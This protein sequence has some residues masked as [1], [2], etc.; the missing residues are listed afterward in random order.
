MDYSNTSNPV[1]KDNIFSIQDAS[2]ESMTIE[3]VLR[4]SL[5]AFCLL[6]GGAVFAWTRSYA[7]IGDISGK[8]ALFSIGAI[9]LHFITIFNANIAK[10]TVPLYAFLEGLILGSVSWMAQRY[11]PGI[12]IQAVT[13]TLGVFMA[14]L[15]V[16]RMGIIRPNEKFTMVL[17]VAT[18]GIGFIYLANWLLSLLGFSGFSMLYG[19]SNIGIGFSVIVC[20]V[21]A[22][23]L[24]V[25]FEF[26]VRQ[27]RTGAPQKLEWIAT[28]GLLVTVIWLYFE[29][30]RLLMKFSTRRE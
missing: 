29:I 8:I 30:L 21:A 3:G 28:L 13:G 1:L 9:A 15:V 24:L 5:I 22:L 27:S 12:V 14:M 26:I 11:Y 7:S 17:F 20:I 2:S 19:S 4:K 16:Y 23:N 6:L 10:I 18:A 25:D